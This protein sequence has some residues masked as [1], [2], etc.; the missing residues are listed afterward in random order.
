MAAISA[1]RA[2]GHG[3]K[4]AADEAAVNAMRTN[5]GNI[6]GVKQL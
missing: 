2:A 3:N 6:R 5:L 4:N 1:A